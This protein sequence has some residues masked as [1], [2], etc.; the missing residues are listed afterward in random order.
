[1]CRYLYGRVGSVE[2]TEL[3]IER[4]EGIVAV[5]TS[6]GG[7]LAVGGCLMADCLCPFQTGVE[8]PLCSIFVP[9]SGNQYILLQ[10]YNL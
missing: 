8:S 9:G 5:A 7:H 6:S 2:G 1:M 10:V 4:P 3:I